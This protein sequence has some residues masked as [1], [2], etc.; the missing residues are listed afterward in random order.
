MTIHPHCAPFMTKQ[1]MVSSTNKISGAASMMSGG[2]KK[3]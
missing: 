1:I 2:M 3:Q